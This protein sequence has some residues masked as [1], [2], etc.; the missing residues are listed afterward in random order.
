MRQTPVEVKILWMLLEGMRFKM[1]SHE[2]HGGLTV[3]QRSVAG[4]ARTQE[5][6]KNRKHGDRLEAWGSPK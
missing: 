3:I 5:K 6:K 2:P 4:K 1:Q